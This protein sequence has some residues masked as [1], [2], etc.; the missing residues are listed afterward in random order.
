MAYEN[1]LSEFKLGKRTLRNRVVNTAHGEQW[2]AGGLLTDHHVDYYTRRAKGGAGLLITFGSAPVC[3]TASTAN[4][5]SLWDERNDAKLTRLADNVH[6]AGAFILAQASHRGPRER[7]AEIDAVLQSPSEPN[8]ADKLTYQGVPQVLTEAGIAGI[9]LDYVNAARRLERVGYD[10]IQITALGTHLIE[11]FWAPALNTRTDKYGGSFENRMRFVTEVLNAVNDATGDDFL[12]SFRI[13]C[14]PQTDLLGLTPDDMQAIAKHLDALD[15]ID[16]FDISGGAGVN[17]ETHT[18]VVPTDTFPIAPY[19]DLTRRMN[20]NLN[21]PVLMAGRVLH[22]DHGEEAVATGVCDLVAMTRAMIAD[23]DVVNKAAAGAADQIRPCVAINE[24]CRRVTLGRSLACSINPA[25]AQTD[26]DRLPKADAGRRLTVVGAG[27]GGLEA[28]RVAAE[29]GFDV[30][31]IERGDQIGGQMI[32]YAQMMQ[33]PHLMDHIRWLERE[34]KRLKVTVQLNKNAADLRLNTNDDVIFATGAETVLPPEARN[35]NITALTD[36]DVLRG[37]ELGHPLSVVVY[38]AEGRQRGGMTA[39]HL[40]ETLGVEVTF[41]FPNDAP[42]EHLEPPNRSAIFR[43]LA[44]SKVQ[45]LPHHGLVA[46]DDGAPSFR[47]SWSD[48]IVTPDADLA[49]FAGYRRAVT[50]DGDAPR[51]GD[52]RAPRL[53]RNAVSE[54]TKAAIGL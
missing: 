34:L 22:P 12:I 18:G 32:D 3:P 50:L 5:V 11:Q 35:L 21:V 43:R 28:A 30:T 37:A 7:P 17:I 46:G 25:V 42:C 10:G 16:F 20:E 51:I 45:I 9:V 36:V 52:C 47:N 49:V 1:L 39:A 33:A 26:L 48:E 24:G 53:L 8:G 29:R 38:D 23:P 15:L 14:D 40:A 19:A 27:P 41:A 31:V 54:A 6:E 4:T 2:A 13:S 44:A